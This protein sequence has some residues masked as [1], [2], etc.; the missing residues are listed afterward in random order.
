[1]REH[2][3]IVGKACNKYCK[4]EIRGGQRFFVCNWIGFFEAFGH[5]L[6]R[7]GAIIIVPLKE[8]NVNSS[9]ESRKGNKGMISR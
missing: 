1:M 6:E 7:V 2:F 5:F 3:L 8:R 4:L 9:I